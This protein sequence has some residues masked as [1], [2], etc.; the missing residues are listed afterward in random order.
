MLPAR[1]ELHEWKMERAQFS[2]S[3]TPAHSYLHRIRR[4]LDPNV[5][6]I[7]M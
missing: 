1:N 4:W 2:P 5:S 7:E 3:I 6:R